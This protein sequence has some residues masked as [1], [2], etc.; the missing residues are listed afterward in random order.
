MSQTAPHT[1]ELLE[2]RSTSF[3][4]VNGRMHSDAFLKEG[5]PFFIIII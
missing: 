5:Q 1:K 4:K 3:I 2:R